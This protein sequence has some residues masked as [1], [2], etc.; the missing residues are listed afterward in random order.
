MV[1]PKEEILRPFESAGIHG[2]LSL[3]CVIS[4]S[5]KHSGIC[6]SKR[7]LH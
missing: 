2:L 6:L 7:N 4:R 3:E 5:D 1:K